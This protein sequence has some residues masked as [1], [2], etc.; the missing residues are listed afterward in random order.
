MENPVET[1]HRSQ[2]MMMRDEITQFHHPNYA[3]HIFSPSKERRRQ[4]LMAASQFS[5][6]GTPSDVI[7]FTRAWENIKC[8]ESSSALMVNHFENFHHHLGA[9]SHTFAFVC[10][11]CRLVVVGFMIFDIES[12]NKQHQ[13][14]NYS[15]HTVSCRSALT[16]STLQ[17][18]T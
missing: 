5:F 17:R 9:I 12:D 6:Q 8:A 13:R 10:S 4:E 7:L 3:N 18:V 15:M 2:E 1:E 11:A 14:R 16:P